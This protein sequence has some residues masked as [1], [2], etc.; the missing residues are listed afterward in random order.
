[1]SKESNVTILKANGE[2]ERFDPQKL[3]RSLSR[4]GAD[5]DA[6]EQIVDHICKEIQTGMSTTHIYRHAFSLL[7]KIKKEPVAM[8]YSLRR[9]V[10]ALGPTGFPFER[11]VSEIFTAK[12]FNVAVGKYVHGECATHEVDML[13]WS[14]AKHIGAELK[15]HNNPGIKTDLKV[16]LYVRERFADIMRG[17]QDK[18]KLP[19]IE[20]GMLITNTKFTTHAITYSECAGLELLGWNYPK[21]GN[22]EDLILETGV[23]PITVLT[24]LS[25]K[26][27]SSLF[28]ENIV[29]CNNVL[30]N[31]DILEKIGISKSK[32]P[33]LLKES[34][35]L[36]TT[37][38]H[39]E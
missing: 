38:N 1:M 25:R 24:S 31:P 4:A 36:C 39:I 30:A 14:N 12:G 17:N 15:F 34:Q 13:A 5:T 20:T 23:Y 35:A 16:A 33:T 9:A 32:I 18:M 11:Y 10:F 21:V 37:P 6:T 22:L 19:Y 3:R 28:K 27:R 26:E 29:V 2:R 8:R 7:R